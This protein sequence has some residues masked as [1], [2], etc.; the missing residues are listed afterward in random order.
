[1][2]TWHWRTIGKIGM[3]DRTKTILFLEE[4][5][6]TIIARSGR[7]YVCV[8]YRDNAEIAPEIRVIIACGFGFS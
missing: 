4:A 8:K 1:M 7:L 5:G 2:P 6:T 3:S